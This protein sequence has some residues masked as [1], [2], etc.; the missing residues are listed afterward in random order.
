MQGDTIDERAFDWMDG[1]VA[2]GLAAVVALW[3]FL[4]GA[5]FPEPQLWPSIANAAHVRASDDVVSG[6]WSL[7]AGRMFAIWGVKASLVAM[8]I[9]GR[10]SLGFFAAFSYLSLR[11]LWQSV[12]DPEE[13]RDDPFFH[14]R[15]APMCAAA[16]ITM[17]PI[18]WRLGQI[19]SPDFIHLCLCLGA[20]Y[21]W[22]RGRARR[23]IFWYSASWLVLGVV[24]GENPV[25][26]A[27]AFAM[28]VADVMTRRRLIDEW[29][30]G[31][32]ESDFRADRHERYAGALL[33]VTGVVGG[34]FISMRALAYCAGAAGDMR[35]V[36]AWI[37]WG[38]NAWN[39]L[40]ASLASDGIF[41]LALVPVAA[42]VAVNLGHRMRRGGEPLGWARV[43]LS[44]VLGLSA[45]VFMTFSVDRGERAALG[46]IREF[47]ELTAESAS[48]RK[49]IFTDGSMD[50]AFRIAF[51]A[52]RF[53]T[54]PLSV[55]RPPNEKE[56]ARLRAVANSLGDGPI[57]AEGGSDVFK[58]WLPESEGNVR[59]SCWQLGADMVRRFS[60]LPQR[61]AGAVSCVVEPAGTL[62]ADALDRRLEEFSART[63]RSAGVVRG[64]FNRASRDTAD[65]FDAL[66]WRLARLADA[67]RTDAELDQDKKNRGAIV[68]ENW[69]LARIL[70]LSNTLLRTKGYELEKFLPSSNLVLTPKEGLWVSLKRADFTLARRYAKEVLMTNRGDPDALFACGMDSLL[71]EQYE[72]AV[73]D[74]EIALRIRPA[75]PAILNNLALAYF[76]LG[77]DT[78]KAKALELAERAAKLYPDSPEV[79]KNLKHLRENSN[80]M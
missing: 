36:A 32:S 38:K 33:F 41:L 6:L 34:I 70:D 73:R 72:D 66:L 5:P 59:M 62:R 29:G 55:I 68:R 1:A 11:T 40:S 42:I 51:A 63:A 43:V 20:V 74:L 27:G 3:A 52:R 7:P 78:N 14:T 50:D 77:G 30:S 71:T 31:D 61:T 60:H 56:R 45:L 28:A 69:E 23:N 10:M 57:F 24:A 53:G 54:E 67:R 26:F 15:F 25:A 39:A 37:A 64:A 35:S 44:S 18:V 80:G 9:A 46:A 47:A 12:R 19:P 79:Q 65:I 16:A 75:E 8:A 21:M 2:C 17:T 49:Y 76:R 4:W 13:A 22:L 48:G 58:A